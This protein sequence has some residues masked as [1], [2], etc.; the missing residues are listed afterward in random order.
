M[1]VVAA[2]AAVAA[3][4]AFGPGP[5]QAQTYSNNPYR[6][7]PWP[8]PWQPDGLNGSID[9]GATTGI[10]A[11]PNTD[12]IWL[13]TRCGRTPRYH[14]NQEGCVFKPDYDMVFKF[15]LDGNLVARFGAGTLGKPH[16]MFVDAEGN[17]WVA[18]FAGGAEY[19]HTAAEV[20]E[21]MRR[22]GLGH[23][24]VKFSPA[25]EVLMRL[26]T[27]GVPGGD[28]THFRNP[29]AVA[30]ALDGSI[31]VGDGH[32]GN[33]NNRLVKFAPDGAF[34]QQ[35]GC[36]DC[37]SGQTGNTAWGEVKDAHA[38][39]FDAEGRLFVA[40]KLNGRIQIFDQDLNLLDVWT[41]FGAPAGLAIDRGIRSSRHRGR[42]VAQ[43][44]AAGRLARQRGLGAGALHRV[45]QDR[46]GDV[47]H[48]RRGA[49]DH[50]RRR[51]T[52]RGGGRPLRQHLLGGD[53]IHAGHHAR[54]AH[55]EVRRHH[56]NA[57]RDVRV[58]GV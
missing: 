8:K 2:L 36:S 31:F 11:D 40:D 10:Y 15:D 45:R 49:A 27:P 58:V 1:T 56:A 21:E 5:L 50:G 30:V 16:S 26:G 39:D 41:Q 28:E 43:L 24:V 12:H 38:L 42:R 20:E 46:L 37:P 14:T 22:R 7:V 17:V 52:G 57:P 18:D 23:Q 13:A 29:S 19:G 32:G 9:F 55:H 35:I 6:P 4:A 33:G 44:A 53:P 51:G 34:I 48:P 47:L 3:I 54:P 25:G